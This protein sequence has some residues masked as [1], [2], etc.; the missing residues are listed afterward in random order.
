[1]H[2]T[3]K[4]PLRHDLQWDDVRLFLALCRSRTVGEAA[5]SL[6]V[7]ASTVSR[8]LVTLEET[9]AASLFD[10]GRD[11]VAP[12]KAAEDLMP[13]A[14]EIEAVVMRFTTAAEGL[15]RTVSGTVRITCPPD[16]A[17]V[18]VA[19]LVA[20]LGQRYPGLR[21][22]I[23]AGESLLDLSRREA[24]LALRVV[25][26]TRGELVVT[27][28]TSV[29]WLLAAAPSLVKS[30]GVVR[31]WTDLPWVGWG[32]RFG[33]A[34]AARWLARHA[35][36]V[37]PI[38]RSDRLTV[39][40]AVLRAGGGV[41]LVPEGSIAHYGLEPVRVA[42]ALRDEAEEWPTDR[43]FLVTHRA[44]RDVPRIR[45]VWDLLVERLSDRK[46]TA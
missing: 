6:G 13:V 36:D 5:R 24:D 18:A 35:R 11:G 34:P 43:L 7:D 21:L 16:V 32:D 19:P 40:I 41:G 38:V 22:E 27:T 8:R 29:R 45:A 33:D 2:R 31:R 10:R 23:E 39:Q 3:T 4:A 28:L 46:R 17:E 26:P 20:E 37:Q 30:L 15:E 44:L 12:T 9:M 42:P 14:E 25:R 1:M